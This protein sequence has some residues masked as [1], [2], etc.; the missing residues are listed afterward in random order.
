MRKMRLILFERKESREYENGFENPKCFGF[1][2][3]DPFVSQSWQIFVLKT[4]Q[5]ILKQFYADIL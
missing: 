1:E 3:T 5:I 2:Q 4:F